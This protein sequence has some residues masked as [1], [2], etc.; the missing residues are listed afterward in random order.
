[1]ILRGRFGYP[2]DDPFKPT[3]HPDKVLL[4]LSRKK[5]TVYFAFSMGDWLCGETL[6]RQAC[7]KMMSEAKQHIFV[8]LTQQYRELWRIAHE[9]PGGL[10][11]PNVVVGITVKKESETWGID[12]LRGVDAAVRLVCAEP[13]LEDLS[14]AVDLMRIDWLII[15]A[16]SKQAGIGGLPTIP[17]FRPPRP[18]VQRLVYKAKTETKPPLKVFLKP[19]LWDYVADGWFLDRIEEF[20]FEKLGW[21]DQSGERL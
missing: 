2:M 19:N 15:G 3:Y 18:W 17:Y 5:P 10:I 8:T 11:P 4:P 14:G 16:Q 20:P 13:L 6:W 12:V 1:M 7:L 9:S 21:K